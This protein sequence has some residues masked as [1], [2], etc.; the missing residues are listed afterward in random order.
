M[1]GGAAIFLV[2]GSLHRVPGRGKGSRDAPVVGGVLDLRVFE[3]EL[4]SGQCR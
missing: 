4:E 1:Q 2:E 3:L